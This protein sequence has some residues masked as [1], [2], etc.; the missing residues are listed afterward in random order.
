[1]SSRNFQFLTACSPNL[2]GRQPWVPKNRHAPIELRVDVVHL[3]LNQEACVARLREWV[4]DKL[5]SASLLTN[6]IPRLSVRLHVAS[7]GVCAFGVGDG[8][9]MTSH[10]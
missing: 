3:P 10:P 1:M 4:G 6:D 5:F 9:S 8:R 2:G 7:G